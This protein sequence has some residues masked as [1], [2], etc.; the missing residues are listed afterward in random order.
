MEPIL[1]KQPKNMRITLYPHQLSAIR[2]METREKQKCVHNSYINLDGNRISTSTKLNISIYADITGFGKTLSVIGLICRDKMKWDMTTKHISKHV[3]N[4]ANCLMYE[5]T[6]IEMNKINSNLVVANSSIIKQWEEELSYTNLKYISIISKKLI[7]KID[8][9]K[10]DV[11]IVS[12]TMYNNFIL[13]W[14][15]FAWKRFIFDEP[16]HVKISKMSEVIAGFT[17]FISATPY[18]LCY[19]NRINSHYA[20][21]LFGYLHGDSWIWEKIIV[22]NNDDFV[23]NSYRI[24]QTNHITHECFQQIYK[25]TRDFISSTISEM[26]AAGNIEGAV[27]ALGGK[28]TDNII[29]LVQKKNREDKRKAENSIQIYQ[30][31]GE[32]YEDSVTEWTTR[33]NEINQ[34]I[35]NL[36]ERFENA[37][38]GEC[39]ITR[40]K[41]VQ[42]VMLSCCQNIFSGKALFSWLESE[43]G[44]NTCPM[45]RETV[46]KDHIISITNG[47]QSPGDHKIE[48]P[49]IQRKKTK[50]EIITNLVNQDESKKFII[51]SS[52]DESWNIMKRIF[53][54]NDIKYAEIVG[55]KT[56][57]ERKI[58]NFKSG[59]IK[60]L[61]LNSTN[62]GAGI[63]LQEATDIILYH[64]MNDNFVTQVIG[65][66]NRI[67][68]TE[69]LTVHHLV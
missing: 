40:E 68:R 55:H 6:Y 69:S 32:G 51:F 38:D 17:W 67:G 64:E 52:W 4:V 33:L 63:N 18:A 31:R 65:R 53:D 62:N 60:V 19:Q 20:R 3:S 30:E 14:K 27:K 61:F 16:T 50:Q 28:T 43:H 39:C 23:R 54:D 49:I 58:T 35:K 15:N 21:Q 56:T 11:V 66:A 22:K 13:K 42:P 41:L 37:L 10:Y 59:D 12:P 1:A 48:E 36:D 24:P 45:C 57:R 25:L 44:K 34:R 29:D 8:V 47:P 5:K 9:T 7:E 46:N 2:M 26:I